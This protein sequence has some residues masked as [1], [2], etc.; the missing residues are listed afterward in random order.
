MSLIL[1]IREV[2]GILPAIA[3]L[4]YAAVRVAYFRADVRIGGNH[5][6]SVGFNRRTAGPCADVFSAR[7]GALN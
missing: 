3:A 1:A 7:D 4:K 5:N 6:V 2:L